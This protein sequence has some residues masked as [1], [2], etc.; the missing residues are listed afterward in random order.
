MF[1][2]QRNASLTTEI[3]KLSDLFYESN[4]GSSM[5]VDAKRILIVLA[6]TTST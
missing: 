6:V 2:D 5:K 1:V 4:K 3:E